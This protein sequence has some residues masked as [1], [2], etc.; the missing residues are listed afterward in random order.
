MN[1]TFFCIDGHTCGCPVRLVT[2]GAP[3]LIGSNMIE[4]RAWFEQLTI[5]RVR[6]FVFLMNIKYN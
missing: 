2:G 4:R 6:H 3:A 1:H 5:S